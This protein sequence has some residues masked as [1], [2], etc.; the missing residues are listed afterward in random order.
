MYSQILSGVEHIH[1]NNIIHRDL[2]PS[3]ILIQL[4]KVKQGKSKVKQAKSNNEA[5]V[6][7]LKICDFG[8]A[9]EM[10]VFIAGHEIKAQGVV[11]T[12]R[13]RSPEMIKKQSYSYETDIWSFGCILFEM[14]ELKKTFL[15]ETE[16]LYGTCPSISRYNSRG[17]DMKLLKNIGFKML[18]RDRRKRPSCKELREMVDDL[19]NPIHSDGLKSSVSRVD[20]KLQKQ[21]DNKRSSKDHTSPVSLA[22]LSAVHCS[23]CF[24]I[25]KFFVFLVHIFNFMI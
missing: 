11:G 18:T 6:R 22:D 9:R 3:N 8:L 15:Y 10:K 23:F 25:F 2:K 16:I 21:D 24:E 14:C 12:E 1:A 19:Q 13:Y 17:E 5:H 4:A 7:V 20:L